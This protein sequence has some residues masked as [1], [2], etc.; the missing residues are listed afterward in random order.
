MMKVYIIDFVQ[1][2]SKHENKP[3]KT[4]ITDL[5]SESRKKANS[6]V[7]L[8]Y[9]AISRWIMSKTKTITLISDAT[10]D[11]NKSIVVTQFRL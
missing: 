5:K 11:Q 6:V 1:R 10:P 8:S 7:L 3:S 4:L 2:Y 9:D